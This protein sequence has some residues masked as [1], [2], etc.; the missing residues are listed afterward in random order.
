VLRRRKQGSTRKK[1]LAL[2][3]LSAAVVSGLGLLRKRTKGAVPATGNKALVREIFEETWQGD[4][5]VV[6]RLVAPE[7]IGHDPS[8]PEP[9]RG[10][11]GIKAFVEKFRESFSNTHITIEEQV[12]EGETVATRWTGRG[13]HT[14]EISGI[15]ATGK[16]VTIAGTSI[17]RLKDGKLIED[18]TTW[19][20]L[21]LFVQLGAIL[22]PGIAQYEPAHHDHEHQEHH[23]H[24][25]FEHQQPY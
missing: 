5:N 6:D 20:S 8:Q 15:A 13:T 24:H 25:E 10:I 17:S 23:E 9:I 21:G 22:A 11:D 3:G 2:T 12:G 7:Y 18:H 14:G 1:T 19:D 16:D 4:V